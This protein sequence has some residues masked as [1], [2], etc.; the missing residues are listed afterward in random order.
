MNG[1]VQPGAQLVEDGEIPRPGGHGQFWLARGFVL[2][3]GG[4]L[5]P[6]GVDTT[7]RYL[8][9]NELCRAEVYQSRN[10]VR[11]HHSV[12]GLD[13]VVSDADDVVEVADGRFQG[14]QKGL[15]VGRLAGADV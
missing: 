12:E 10:S 5:S 1:F 3:V 9:S 6:C 2:N 11:A 8:V 7:V 4:I 15:L 14:G 13:V